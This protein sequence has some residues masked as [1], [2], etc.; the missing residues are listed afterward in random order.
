[1]RWAGGRDVRVDRRD[2]WDPVGPS[3]M[4]YASSD[5]RMPA[6]DI[7]RET[8][9]ILPE[10]RL[11]PRETRLAPRETRMIARET[12]EETRAPDNP[13]QRISEMLARL[14]RAAAN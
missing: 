7:P 11:R 13:D 3:P 10:T 12:R 14:S 5:A 2:I 1:M 9:S 8:R 4:A 6:A